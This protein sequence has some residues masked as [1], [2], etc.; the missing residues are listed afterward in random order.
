MEGPV[1]GV[2]RPRSIAAVGNVSTW[3][4]ERVWFSARKGGGC[5][6][7]LRQGRGWH[8]FFRQGAGVTAGCRGDGRRQG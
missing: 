1:Q 6:E 3:N 2:C 5:E 7:V 4:L 8:V